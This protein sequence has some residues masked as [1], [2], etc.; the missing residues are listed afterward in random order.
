LRAFRSAPAAASSTSARTPRAIEDVIRA[1][2]VPDQF[3]PVVLD[4]EADAL[5]D[6]AFRVAPCCF[7]EVADFLEELCFEDAGD[8]LAALPCFDGA[9]AFLA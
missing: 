8:F 9:A 6:A 3:G 2:R 7:A 1:S 4:R 5:R